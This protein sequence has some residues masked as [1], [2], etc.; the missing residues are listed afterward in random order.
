MTSNRRDMFYLNK[1]QETTEIDTCGRSLVAVVKLVLVRL[2][3]PAPQE[4][5]LHQPLARQR[6][7]ILLRQ[8]LNHFKL[9]GRQ[10]SNVYV[11]VP[12]Y[13]PER[14]SASELPPGAD[15]SPGVVEI[16]LLLACQLFAESLIAL[17]PELDPLRFRQSPSPP[18]SSDVPFLRYK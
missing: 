9:Y 3:L 14:H 8:G 1:K 12:P 13:M 15:P 17:G 16:V 6:G 7:E 2:R 11:F 4:E 10:L 5:V 18:Y